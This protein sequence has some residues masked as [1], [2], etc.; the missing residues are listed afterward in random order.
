MVHNK[1]RK[2]ERKKKRTK[3]RVEILELL[4]ENPRQFGS[5]YFGGVLLKNFE[6][7]KKY[8]LSLLL[9]FRPHLTELKNFSVYSFLATNLNAKNAV[10]LLS[11]P[12]AHM[13]SFS[14]RHL[15]QH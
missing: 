4:S 6:R 1:I 5:V 15:Q 9:S 8:V 10:I 12:S 3:C 14:S 13:L 2:K 7:K 11:I